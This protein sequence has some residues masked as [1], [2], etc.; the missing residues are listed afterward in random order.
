MKNI[1]EINAEEY[2]I[3]KDTDDILNE[4]K[5]GL[6]I[7]PANPTPDSKIQGET[8]IK[9]KIA[10]HYSVDI[11]NGKWSIVEDFP[12]IVV[13]D[14]E[15]N[16]LYETS[17]KIPVVKPSIGRVEIKEISLN[18]NLFKCLCFCLKIN[19]LGDYLYPEL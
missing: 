1:I 14:S 15:G 9:P 16:N 8:F 18:I 7:E 19:L 12:V 17:I 11:E 4:M 3:D 2:Y 13:V 10:E 6:I 5:N